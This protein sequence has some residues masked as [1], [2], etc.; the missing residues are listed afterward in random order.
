MP[1]QTYL[2]RDHSRPGV[3]KLSFISPLDAD[4]VSQV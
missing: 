1:K 2:S 4:T 3:T